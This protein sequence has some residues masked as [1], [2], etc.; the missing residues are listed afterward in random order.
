MKLY[1]I[2]FDS[3]S[4]YV[5]AVSTTQ[6]T[7]IWKQHSKEECGEDYEEDWEPESIALVHDSGVIRR[8]MLATDVEMC[9]GHP[10]REATTHDSEG[11]P[12]CAECGKSLEKWS[13]DDETTL[14]CLRLANYDPPLPVIAS[15]SD[16]QVQQVERWAGS[17]HFAAAGNDVEVGPVPDFLAPHKTV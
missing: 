13:R 15:W 5:E 10:H 14:D 17:V 8:Q 9:E 6:A 3:E 4:Y 11:V 16:E 2:L 7:L 12:L 1:H